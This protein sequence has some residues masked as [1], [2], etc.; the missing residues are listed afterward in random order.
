MILG[1]LR[2]KGSNI[3]SVKFYTIMAD[4]I[5]DISNEEQLVICFRWVDECWFDCESNPGIYV[6]ISKKYKF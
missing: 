1:L 6:Y 3:Q 4:E 2:E 5:A